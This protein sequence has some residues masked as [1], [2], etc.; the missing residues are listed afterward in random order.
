MADIAGLPY[1]EVTFAA[2][3]TLTDDGGLPAALG[4]GGITNVFVFSHGWNNSVQSARALYQGMFTLLAGML[5]PTLMESAVV[6]VLWP[7]L[8]FPEDDP[9]M[10]DTPSTGARL[11]AALAPS[12]PGHEQALTAMGSMLDQQP[13]DPGQLARFH[14]M[15]S[16]LVTTPALATEDEGP[17]AAITGD[18]SAVFGHAAA[19]AQVHTRDAEEL[20]N[21]FACLWSGAR[22]VLRTMSYY[23]MKNRAGVVGRDGLGPLIW[24][25]RTRNR[26]PI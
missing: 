22:E 12:F 2:D 20:P 5:G 26:S 21:P 10:A 9:G 4:G 13:Q 15:A 23:E 19:M 14:Q 8:L 7:S 11:A 16:A 6:G 1:F 17:A 3:G 18:T 25:T 24:R